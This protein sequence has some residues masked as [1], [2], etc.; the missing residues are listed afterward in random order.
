MVVLRQAAVAAAL[1][2]IRILAPGP[3]VSA[4]NLGHVRDVLVGLAAQ[5]SL[6]SHGFDVPAETGELWETISVD[7]DGRY[8][9]GLWHT[10]KA[11]A[12]V[13][14]DH[15]TWA[16][17]AGISGTEANRMYATASDGLL[18]TGEVAVTAGVGHAMLPDDIHSVSLDGTEEPV[19]QLHLYGLCIARLQ[20]R[21]VFDEEGRC[22]L[23]DGNAVPSVDGGAFQLARERSSCDCDNDDAGPTAKL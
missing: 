8:E 21:R 20:G 22:A 16:V 14:H 3:Q 10:T 7:P 13:P 5:S 23:M 4:A 6:W 1:A 9:L 19:M 15:T 12:T 2:K 18:V 11:I 17:V